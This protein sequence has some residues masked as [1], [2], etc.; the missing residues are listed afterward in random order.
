MQDNYQNDLRFNTGRYPCAICNKLIRSNGRKLE[1]SLCNLCYHFNCTSLTLADYKYFKSSSL[2]WTCQTCS[3][4]I[5]PFHSICFRQRHELQRRRNPC[6]LVQIKCESDLHLI[7]ST[8][9]LYQDWKSRVELPTGFGLSILWKVEELF[10]LKLKI[11]ILM[12]TRIISCRF[13]LLR[14]LNLLSP[15]N[16]LYRLRSLVCLAS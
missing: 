14:T 6:N 3:K 7:T 12:L 1:C 9:N 2:G 11:C 4:S 13:A 15:S 8:T 16:L 10:L 5:F